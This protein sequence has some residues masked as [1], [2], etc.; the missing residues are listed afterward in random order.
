VGLELDEIETP[1]LVGDLTGVQQVTL[2]GQVTCAI[3]GMN[4]VHCWGRSQH[5][6]WELEG[7]EA[8]QDVSLNTPTPM[9]QL[10]AARWIHSSGAR[11]CAVLQGGQ[12]TCWGTTSNGNLGGSGAT[13]YTV[14]A[15]VADALEVQLGGNH[16][17]AREANNRL[18]CWGSNSSAQMGNGILEN[19]SYPPTEVEVDAASHLQTSGRTTCVLDAEGQVLCWGRNGG[20]GVP[21]EVLPIGYDM[22][23]VRGIDVD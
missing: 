5:L 1:M 23:R 20:V 4:Q 9:V 3:D 13:D 17:C 6:F 14:L 2:G 16:G 21:L 7:V 12:A 19:R 22:E 15:N 8:E 11:A 10:G 18:I